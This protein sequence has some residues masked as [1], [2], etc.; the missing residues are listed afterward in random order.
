MYVRTVTRVNKSGSTTS[1]VQLASNQWDPIRKR[2]VATVVAN[3]GRVDQGG[4]DQVANLAQA[5][6]R[7]LG[8]SFTTSAEIPEATMSRPA[9]GAWI[10]DGVWRQLGLDRIIT[11]W[12]RPGPGRRKNMDR[13]ERIIFGMVA[14]RCL[15][16][17]S[18]LAGT[19]W[20]TQDV[21]IPA[22]VDT[23]S[24]DECYRA[25]DWLIEAGDCFA[26]QVYDS[27]TDLVNLEVDLVFF[28]T[29]STYFETETGDDPMPRDS[30]GQICE[31]DD[32]VTTVG[33]R[34]WGKSK[35]S[36][37]DLPQIV[38]GMAV[39]RGGIPIRVWSWPGNTS[40]SALIRQARSELRDWA[41]SKVVWVAD[42]GFS[43]QA[44]RRELMR[45]GDGY[46]LGEKLRS[47]SA[48]AEA[49]LSRP[50]RYRTV[51]GNLQVKEVHIGA[52]DRF[53]VCYNPDEA[54]R[55]EHTRTRL[56]A[57]LEAMIDGS[58]E[59]T[60]TKRAEL[61]GR[62]STMP[63]LNRYLRVTPTGLLRIDQ[64]TITEETNLDG[65]YL[66]RTCDPHLG[67]DD[68]A[69]GY[70]QLL[71]VERGWR[72]MKTTLEL[73]PVY[74]HLEDRIRAH[75]ILCWLALL[76]IRII[77]TRTGQTWATIRRDM[78]RLHQI[79]YDTPDGRI[80]THTTTT[81]A[82]QAILDKL[83]LDAPPRAAITPLASSSIHH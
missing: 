55:D 2:S 27:V 29:T 80:R 6:L 12:T 70:K 3:L 83:H 9:G 73:R 38:V 36:R 8:E 53:I 26:R 67:A 81:P 1:Y 13:V 15:A 61:R 24:D 17:S 32:A 10:L 75:V 43:S 44:N 72:D 48:E 22:M 35:D 77:E 78:Q 40:D 57:R 60:A 45:G 50:G 52:T 51:T 23:V 19:Q 37:D 7:Y 74:H 69:Q 59:M 66:L 5:C 65:K 46:I 14:D 4:A 49:A 16:P 56:V 58:D 21:A 76:L 11:A 18:K 39:T 28:D 41:L 31:E 82:Q 62:I 25:M 64:T 42:R 63:G 71:E 68:V 33:F 20:M 54:V 79:T 34:T 47:G 30:T